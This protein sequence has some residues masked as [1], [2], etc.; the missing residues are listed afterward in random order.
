MRRKREDKE[1]REIK[2]R[3]QPI[4][5]QEQLFEYKVDGIKERFVIKVIDTNPET[6]A[7][8]AII[9]I[10][11]VIYK[12]YGERTVLDLPLSEI[13]PQFDL[14]NALVNELIETLKNFR[15]SLFNTPIDKPGI[16][17]YIMLKL[18]FLLDMPRIC[19]LFLKRVTEKKKDD[20]VGYKLSENPKLND[21]RINIFSHNIG[22]FLRDKKVKSVM[23]DMGR[24]EKLD[25]WYDLLAESYLNLLRKNDT[26]IPSK[27]KEEGIEKLMYWFYQ[28]YDLKNGSKAAGFPK[29]I[30]KPL[31]FDKPILYLLLF[32]FII[33]PPVF[34]FIGAIRLKFLINWGYSLLGF[35]IFILFIFCVYSFFRL[36]K[37]KTY[38]PF[39]IF[40]PRLAAGIVVGYGLFFFVS[41]FWGF[42]YYN[43]TP[44]NLKLI[45]IL[46]STILVSS[47]YVYNRI[48]RLNVKS[49]GLKTFQLLSLGL[50]ESTLLGFILSIFVEN[51]PFYFAKSY[52]LPNLA[53]NFKCLNEIIIFIP[54]ANVNIQPFSCL[55][56]IYAFEPF[57]LIFWSALSLFVAIIFQ[58]I[59]QEE[60]IS[61]PI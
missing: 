59:W 31:L 1:I 12:G 3:F 42:L 27:V 35:Y 26:V 9:R 55:P 38:H 44:S 47:F 2:E 11:P 21:T 18:T 25:E 39:T 10:T 19:I 53:G 16:Q 5:G 52:N 15:Q 34:L 23:E 54:L 8:D 32:F 14:K 50:L 22:G 43:I 58:L 7:P 48:K 57:A 13:S 37:D 40:I 4:I 33:L 56:T 49:P 36:F 30:F 24:E 6:E 60:K 45:I 41:E 28:R 17:H 46:V 61:E 51:L 20:F 29:T